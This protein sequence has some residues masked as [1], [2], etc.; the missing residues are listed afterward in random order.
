LCQAGYVNQFLPMPAIG[1]FYAGKNYSTYRCSSNFPG[2]RGPRKGNERPILLK[3][4]DDALARRNIC[5]E[6]DFLGF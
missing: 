4:R 5:E 3:Q 6:E 1:I 2:V